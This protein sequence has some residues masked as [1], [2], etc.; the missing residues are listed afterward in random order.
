MITLAPAQRREKTTLKIDT[1]EGVG[2]SGKKCGA[3][4]V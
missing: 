3:A 2:G 4:K 1:G